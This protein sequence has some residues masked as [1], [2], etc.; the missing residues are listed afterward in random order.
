MNTSTSVATPEQVLLR[1]DWNVIRRLDGL[2]QGDYRTLFYG[3]GVDF[4]DLRE[5]Q[6][7]DDIRYI[8]WNVT[9]RMDSPY[10][11]QYH[12][13]REI[14]AWFL[15]DLSP[16]VDFGTTQNQKRNMLVDFVAVLA[17]LLTR[18]GNRVGAMMLGN[19]IQH[20]VPARGGKLQVLRLINDL[21]KQTRLARAPFTNLKSIFDGAL[22]SIKRRSLIFVISDFISEPGWER[23]LSLLG[24]RHEAIAVRLVDPREVELPDI[25]MA[26]M[27]DAETGAQMF[28]DTHDAKFRKQFFAAAQKREQDLNAAF[29]RAG[30][31]A[32]PLSTDDDLARAIVRFAKQRQQARRN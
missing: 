4:A 13:D 32:M 2:L 9:A 11:R 14:T 19:G 22:N 1:L 6:P 17:R 23:A 3:F 12:E 5:Y 26:V 21:Q 29:K 27:E 25:G 18:H 24:Q 8:D 30:V 20:T 10:V 16:S 7:G 28:V 15:L 31:D